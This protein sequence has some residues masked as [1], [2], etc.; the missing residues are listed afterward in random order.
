MGMPCAGIGA[1]WDSHSIVVDPGRLSRY[2]VFACP[3]AN[4][5][6]PLN[7]TIK[8]A[9]YLFGAVEALTPLGCP[10]GFM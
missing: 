9:L 2:L 1:R 5:E 8:V 10:P 3:R 6:V 4:L 7:Q